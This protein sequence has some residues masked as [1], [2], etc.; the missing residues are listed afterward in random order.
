MKALLKV[1]G[2]LLARIH[3]L[4]VSGITSLTII[5][6]LAIARNVA[7]E[8]R[9]VAVVKKAVD[10]DVELFTWGWGPWSYGGSKKKRAEA[11]A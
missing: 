9:E 3:A 10:E 6:S 1:S 2:H 7:T 8:E 11:K 5:F 4:I